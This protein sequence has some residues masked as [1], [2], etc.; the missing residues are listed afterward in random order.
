MNDRP[1]GLLRHPA[2][3][4]AALGVLLLLP[5]L[6]PFAL[7]GWGAFGALKDAVHGEVARGLPGVLLAAWIV[8]QLGAAVGLL[9]RARRLARLRRGG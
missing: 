1:T 4:P 3:A 9:A 2:A 5:V 6:F 7:M 8:V